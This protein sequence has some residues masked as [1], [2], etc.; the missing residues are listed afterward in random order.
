MKRSEITRRKCTV[1]GQVL[2]YDKATAR[3]L[4]QEHSEEQECFYTKRLC[5]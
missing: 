5:I 1:R 4:V 3:Y 2:D